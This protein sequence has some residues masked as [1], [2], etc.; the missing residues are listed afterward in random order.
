[1]INLA[2]ALIKNR[3]TICL[4]NQVALRFW[5]FSFYTLCRHHFISTYLFIELSELAVS[6]VHFPALVLSLHFYP[7]H[8][9]K[10]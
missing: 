3:A 2:W 8:L 1:M 4:S 9:E 10:H 6:M 5:G 7:I